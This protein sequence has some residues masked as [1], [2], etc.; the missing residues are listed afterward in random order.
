[1]IAD[2]YESNGDH[3]VAVK[4]NNKVIILEGEKYGEG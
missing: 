3:V 2:K 1:M 4:I